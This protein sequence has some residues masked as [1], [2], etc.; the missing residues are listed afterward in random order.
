MPFPVLDDYMSRLRQ[1]AAPGHRIWLDPKGHAQ[2]RYF[3]CTLTSVFQP[4]RLL[5]SGRIAGYEA[6]IRS[7]S[8][9]SPRLSVWKL[10]EGAASDDESVALD[11]LCRMLHAINFYRQPQ[12]DAADLYLSVHER[13]LTGVS[14][15]HGMAFRHVLDSLGLPRE[16]IVLQLPPGGSTNRFLLQYVGDNY[17]RNGFRIAIHACDAA[18]GL[19]L[20]QGMTPDAVSLDAREMPDQADVSELAAQ[21]HARGISLVFKRVEKAVVA[22]AI[23]GMPFTEGCVMAQGRLW[24]QPAASLAGHARWPQPAVATPGPAREAGTGTAA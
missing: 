8:E 2:G 23:C 1:A 7:T 6:F 19:R 12:A 18:Y 24:D 15:N 21:C 14:S 4:V 22:D 16:R 17:R 5:A 3:N 13:L 11:R 10:L 9:T 20:L